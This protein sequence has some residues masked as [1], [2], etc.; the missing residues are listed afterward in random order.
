MRTERHSS[1]MKVLAGSERWGASSVG[2]SSEPNQCQMACAWCIADLVFGRCEKKGSV[3]GCRTGLSVC[4]A[5]LDKGVLKAAL[6]RSHSSTGW[7][8]SSISLIRHPTF[9]DNGVE[10]CSD[11]QVEMK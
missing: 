6:L 4:S 5:V 1:T 7:P 11:T 3:D 10:E 9:L 8:K 2:G